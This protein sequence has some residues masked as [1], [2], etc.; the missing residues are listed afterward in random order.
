MAKVEKLACE[1]DH[2]LSRNELG[3]RQLNKDLLLEVSSASECSIQ[4]SQRVKLKEMCS[5]I[6]VCK[7]MFDDAGTRNR[8]HKFDL[9]ITLFSSQGMKYISAIK[10]RYKLP[11][12]KHF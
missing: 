2:T 10:P 5:F 4:K 3:C 12:M 9:S 8:S 1:N 11:N 7:T 6:V